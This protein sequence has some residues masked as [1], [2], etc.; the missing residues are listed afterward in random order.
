MAIHH[1]LSP[2]TFSM[3][4]DPFNIQWFTKFKEQETDFVETTAGIPIDQ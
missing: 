2:L 3:T 1:D 4:E